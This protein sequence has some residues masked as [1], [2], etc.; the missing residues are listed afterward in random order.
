MSPRKHRPVVYAKKQTPT[1]LL[2]EC[3][4]TFAL[5]ES[6]PLAVPIGPY[7]SVPRTGGAGNATLGV[8]VRAGG[9]VVIVGKSRSWLEQQCERF[10]RQVAR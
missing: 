7:T 8:Y 9:R 2:P 10:I 5:P 3:S 4:L 6:L 1:Y